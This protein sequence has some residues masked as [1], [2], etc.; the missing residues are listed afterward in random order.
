QSMLGG[1]LLG[2]KKLAEAEPLL[3]R[4]YEGLKARADKIPVPA[5][6][7]LAEATERIVRLYQAMNQPGKAAALLRKEDLD[8]MMP[9]GAAAFARGGDVGCVEPA[10]HHRRSAFHARSVRRGDARALTD[11]WTRRDGPGQ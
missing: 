3:V 5:R 10:T 9:N 6:S 7:N 2:Q 4:G 11:P 8:R 1:S